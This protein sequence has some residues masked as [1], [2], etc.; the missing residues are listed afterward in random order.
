MF[1][2]LFLRGKCL[3]PGLLLAGALVALVPGRMVLAQ[4][5]PNTFV[6]TSTADQLDVAPGDG[7]CDS[8]PGSGTRCTL[9]AA[10]MEA[11]VLGGMQTIRVPSGT[12]KLTLKGAEEDGARSGDLDIW[13]NDYPHAALDGA[14]YHDMAGS[15]HG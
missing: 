11:N 6:V 9:R 3:L 12:Y 10:L 4:T 15:A 2:R 5:D 8:D 13:T 7:R 14:A 1:Y